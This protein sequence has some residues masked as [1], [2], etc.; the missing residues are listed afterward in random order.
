MAATAIGNLEIVLAANSAG[1]IAGMEQAKKALRDGEKNALT[2]GRVISGTFTG[3]GKVIS[4]V[5][6]KFVN[7]KTA[8]LAATAAVGAGALVHSLDAAADSIDQLGKASKRLGM[9]VEDLSALRFAAGESGIE[10]ESLA[11]MVSKASKEVAELVEKGSSKLKLGSVSVQLTDVTGKIRN[12]N[13]LMPDLARGIESAGSEA[14]QLM[15][16]Q[17]IFGR[18]GADQFVTLLKESGTYLAGMADQQARARRLGAIYNDDQVEKLTAYRDAVGRVGEAWMGVKVKLMT[19]IAPSLTQFLDTFAERT[20]EIPASVS[21]FARAFGVAS[22]DDEAARRAG[23]S[24][25]RVTSGLGNVLI[26]SGQAAAKVAMSI[27]TDGIGTLGV[28]FGIQIMKTIRDVTPSWLKDAI[29]DAQVGSEAEI[30]RLQ[31]LRIDML[32]AQ[33]DLAA[34]RN[35]GGKV[36]FDRRSGDVM[37]TETTAQW[38]E[39]QIRDILGKAGSVDDAVAV[40][41]KLTLAQQRTFEL[42]TSQV[43]QQQAQL[44]KQGMAAIAEAYSQGAADVARAAEQAGAAITDL[45]ANYG[46]EAFVGPPEPPKEAATHHFA[47]LMAGMRGLLAEAEETGTKLQATLEKAWSKAQPQIEREIAR[48]QKGFEDLMKEAERIRFELYPEEKAE[49]EIQRI[50]Q[51]RD[52]LIKLG[53]YSKL[54][55]KDVEAAIAKIHASLKNTEKEATKTLSGRMKD[56]IEGFASSASDAF[57]DLVIDGKANFGELAKSWG[58]MLLS[59]AMQAMIFRPLFNGMAGMFDRNFSGTAIGGLP[60]GQKASGGSVSAG[61]SYWVGERGPELLRFSS[62]GNITPNHQLSKAGGGTVVQVID[63]RSSGAAPKVQ[64]STG[65]DGRKMISVLIRD[66]VK[67]MFGDGSM[68]RTMAGTFGIGRRATAR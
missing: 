42:N 63:Q 55:E 26:T 48:R 39:R 38:L 34:G 50:I 33:R 19:E 10:F 35:G 46:A 40:I 5:I 3:S 64:E 67:K 36:L 4:G 6:G 16:A 56:A 13:E 18:G 22:G 62:A 44:A 12:I 8:I 47:G 25:Q 27:L 2:F 1:F 31:K 11:S 32:A 45:R 49:A 65:P 17:K 29:G 14:E 15:L 53:Y 68:D 60:A 30:E 41:E 7:L 66:E 9:T 61:S 57:A 54:S 21:A 59:M 58:K 20:A 51:V 24:V 37:E 28:T 23:E 52:E 43:A